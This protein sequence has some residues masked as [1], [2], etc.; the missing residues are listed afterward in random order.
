MAPQ[1]TS[2][3][4]QQGPLQSTKTPAELGGVGAARLEGFAARRD[5]GRRACAGTVKGPLALGRRRRACAGPRAPGRRRWSRVRAARWSSWLEP[6]R[7]AGPLPLKGPRFVGSVCLPR[8][9]GK[10]VKQPDGG[11][12]IGR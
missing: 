3:I 2:R 12:R 11:G 10:G 6:R 1:R 8:R 9:G 7:L 5:G 4:C